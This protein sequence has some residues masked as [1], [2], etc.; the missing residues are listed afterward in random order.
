MRATRVVFAAALGVLFVASCG[1]Q[2]SERRGGGEIPDLTGGSGQAL[3]DP[4]AAGANDAGAAGAL[5]TGPVPWCDAYRILN[6]VCQQCHQAPPLNGAPFPLLSYDDTQ[7]RYPFKS[8]KPI[9]QQMQTV[10]GNG[11]M[12][13]QGDPTVMPAVQPLPA[14]QKATLLAW[15]AEGALPEG[16]TDCPKT[17][18][19]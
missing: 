15:L 16:G 14:P 13:Y 7:A 18:E 5:P 4:G 9:W 2:S 12:P 17:C 8:S 6:C 3:P 11:F 1:D 19:W 10:V